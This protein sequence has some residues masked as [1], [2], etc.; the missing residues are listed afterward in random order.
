MLVVDTSVAVKWVIPESGEG[1][2]GDTDAT[3]ALLPYNMIAPDCIAAE[4]ANALYKKVKAGEIGR[5]QAFASVEILPEIV[6]LVPTPPLVQAAFRLSMELMHPVHDC[7]F[8]ALAMQSEFRL[9]TADARFAPR[10]RQS[11]PALP[12]EMLGEF[13]PT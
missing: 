13:R 12:V 4:F 1:I 8:L 5:D 2:E 6:S 11:N 7:I 3:L 9:I 10:C